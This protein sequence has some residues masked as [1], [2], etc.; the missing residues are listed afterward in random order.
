MSTRALCALADAAVGPIASL[1]R[2]FRHELE[3]CV[4][5]QGSAYPERRYFSEGAAG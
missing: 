5:N 1:V 2:S 3:A 4:A